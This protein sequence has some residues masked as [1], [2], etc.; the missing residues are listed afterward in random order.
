[1]IHYSHSLLSTLVLDGE[2]VVGSS[3][4]CHLML[5]VVRYLGHSIMLPYKLD[6]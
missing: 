2:E 4:F 1:M 5:V 6:V 3:G